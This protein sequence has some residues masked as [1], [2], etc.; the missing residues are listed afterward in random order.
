MAI[1]NNNLS[2]LVGVLIPAN[3][4]FSRCFGMKIA[5]SYGYGVSKFASV[6]IMERG[7]G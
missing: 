6:I 7:H 5:Y 1:N 3:V 2:V 4:L